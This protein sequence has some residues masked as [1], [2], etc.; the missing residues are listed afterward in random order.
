[1]VQVLRPM[2]PRKARKR[3]TPL[4]PQ[5]ASFQGELDDLFEEVKKDPSNDLTLR[6]N[7]FLDK[8][9]PQRVR[10]FHTCYEIVDLAQPGNV[11]LYHTSVDGST[12]CSGD[13]ISAQ[14][15][16]I[17]VQRLQIERESRHLGRQ[18][19]LRIS[20][21]RVVNGNSYTRTDNNC[22]ASS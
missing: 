2:P 4:H 14:I 5:L 8:E 11:V 22:K 3:G 13:M 6:V 12:L 16:M 21:P 10:L 1:M 7:Q 17:H 18:R 20:W 15:S 19:W 9:T